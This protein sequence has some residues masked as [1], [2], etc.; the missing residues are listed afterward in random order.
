MPQENT[1][2]C[3]RGLSVKDIVSGI[4]GPGLVLHTFRNV[5]GVRL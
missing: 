1:N 5:A 4:S 2:A 3:P